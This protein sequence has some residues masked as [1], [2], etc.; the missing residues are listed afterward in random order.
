MSLSGRALV[1]AGI[2]VILTAAGLLLREGRVLVLAIPF[3]LYSGLLFYIQLAAHAP[4]LSVHRTLETERIEEGGHARVILSIENRGPSISTLG[5]VERLPEDCWIAEGDTAVFRSLPAGGTISITYTLGAPRGFHTFPPTDVLVWDRFSLSTGTLTF[6]EEGAIFA[7]PR[8]EG[9]ETF[10]IRP[11]RTRAF[12]GPV[13]A[14]VGGS[15]LEFFGC[16]EYV[17]GDDIRRINWRAFA[18]WNELVIDEFEQERIAD[19]TVILD[20]RERVNMRVAGTSVFD[21]AVRAAASLGLHFLDQGNYVGL[22]IYGNYLDWTFPS[23][24]RAQKER[25]LEALTRAQTAD[26]PVFEDLRNIPARLFPPRS[27]LILVSP[28]ADEDDVEILGILRA[29]EYQILL[30]SPD[31]LPSKRAERPTDESLGLAVRIA[32]LR[33][34]LLLDTLRRIGVVVIDWEVTEPLTVPFH[35]L[36]KGGWRHRW[37]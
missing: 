13:K 33:R 10:P 1:I 9:I 28:L 6:A 15:G 29:R 23:T 19:V 24:G 14:N 16:R 4:A 17:P 36:V 20:A 7:Q 25:I 34:G 27:Q 18:R 2:G 26:K 21:Q 12:A 30:V 37:R 32:Q 11:R 5:L 8:V 35:G 3:L 22:L 31:V